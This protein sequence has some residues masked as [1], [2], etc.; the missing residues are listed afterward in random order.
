MELWFPYSRVSACVGVSE[1]RA[2]LWLAGLEGSG[3]RAKNP[4]RKKARKSCQAVRGEAG[5]RINFLL[6]LGDEAL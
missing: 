3:D 2:E 5:D 6:G 4:S 1:D